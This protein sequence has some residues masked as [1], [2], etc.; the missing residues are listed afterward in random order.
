MPN[1]LEETLYIVQKNNKSPL[2]VRFVSDGSK[3]CSFAEFCKIAKNIDYQIKGRKIFISESLVIV[4][5]DWWLSRVDC[6]SDNGYGE[7]WQ[8]NQVPSKPKKGGIEVLTRY[9]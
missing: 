4:G 6:N 7:K 3:Y 5:D 9:G 2:D 1:L 8:F